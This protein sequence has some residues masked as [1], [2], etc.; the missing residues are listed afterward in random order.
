MISIPSAR[1]VPIIIPAGAKYG[2]AG[3]KIEPGAGINL[4]VSSIDIITD[5][6]D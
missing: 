4:D 5:I 3:L 1:P 6:D 2:L